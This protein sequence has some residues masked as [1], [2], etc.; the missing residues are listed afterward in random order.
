MIDREFWKSKPD[1]KTVQ[2]KVGD[3]NDPSELNRFAFD[4]L[5]WALIEEA[6]FNV[7]E[8]LYNQEGNSA[9]KLT[10]D[11]RTYIFWAAY[12][13]NLKFMKFLLKEGAQTDI[14]DEHG[15]SLL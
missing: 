2:E 7:L 10:H 8:Y 1:L 9:N 5:S 4:P 15:Y 3:G 11:G 12:R 13:D 14:I 6:P